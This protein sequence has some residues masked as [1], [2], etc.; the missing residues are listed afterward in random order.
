M[1]HYVGYPTVATV[2]YYTSG[3]RFNGAKPRTE[4][5]LI[6]VIGVAFWCARKRAMWKEDFPRKQVSFSLTSRFFSVKE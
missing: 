4:S 3:F 2:A 5:P 1:E 6:L